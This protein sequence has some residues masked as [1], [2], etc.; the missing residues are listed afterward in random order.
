MFVAVVAFVFIFCGASLG[1]FLR[2]AFPEHHLNSDTRDV[3]RVG[4]V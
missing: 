4:Q 2:K 3:V 1:I